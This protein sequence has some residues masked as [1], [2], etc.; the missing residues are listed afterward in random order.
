MY[1]SHH[2]LRA[3]QQISKCNDEDST[4][5]S[6]CGGRTR[7][8]NI[9]GKPIGNPS[10]LMDFP[11]G[12]GDFDQNHVIFAAALLYYII[13]IGKSIDFR[14]IFYRTGRFRPKLQENRRFGGFDP[15]DREIAAIWRFP[16][17]YNCDIKK[18]IFFTFIF[19][20][21]YFTFWVFWERKTLYFFMYR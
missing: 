3:S 2:G 8:I 12:L 10:I 5:E 11:I 18:I 21:F 16:Q 20:I 17:E 4:I 13:S 19:I 9:H 1:P 6:W 7:V 15:N 14:W